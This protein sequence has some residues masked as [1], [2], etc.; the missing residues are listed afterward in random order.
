MDVVAAVNDDVVLNRNLLRS[1]LVHEPGVRLQ[2]QRGFSSAGAAYNAALAACT[3]EIVVF[4]HQ[5]VYV[6]VGW[7]ASL[8]RSVAYLAQ[9]DPTWGVLGLYGITKSGE[10]V[11]HVW[12]SGLNMM[13]GRSFDRPVSVDSVDELLI[14]VRKAAGLEFDRHVPGFHLYA[15]DLVQT[16]LNQG[17]GAYVICAPVVHNSRPV[18]YLDRSYF[19]SHA[20]LMRKWHDRLP[21][22]NCTLT[23]SSSRVSY[24]RARARSAIRQ[25]TLAN[26]RRADL[27]R[28]FDSIEVARE[29]GLE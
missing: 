7:T 22:H 8:R 19:R 4:V 18:P 5:D 15:T 21:I 29:L 26:V 12:S 3:S 20:Y 10:L 16:A 9:V 25:L 27:D 24:F 17:F 28:N 13:L 11:G 14:V 23:I 6:P 2:L 1:R